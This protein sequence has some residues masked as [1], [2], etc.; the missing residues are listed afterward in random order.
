[1]GKP[2]RDKGQREERSI[3]HAF[4]D[5][6]IGAERV[7][8]SGSAGGSYVGDVSIPVMGEDWVF[9]AKV[10]AT[11]FSQIYDWLGS[12]KGLFIRRDRAPRLV[13]LRESDFI[14]I[15]KK[16]QGQ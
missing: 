4:Q 3:V 1:M 7:P 9:E 15:I 11:G 14:N 10:R 6:G 12:H 5:H 8:L 16:G 2:S 13:V